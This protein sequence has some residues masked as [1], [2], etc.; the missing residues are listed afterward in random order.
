MK[1]LKRIVI[2]VLVLAVLGGLAWGGTTLLRKRSTASSSTSLTQVVSVERGNLTASIS[3]TGE[4]YAPRQA[5]LGFDVTRI[6]LVEL[7]VAAGQVAKKGDVLARIDRAPLERAVEQAQANLLSAEDALAEAKDP[8]AALDR[9][10]AELTVAQAQTAL[11]ETRQSLEDLQNPDLDAA[12]QA[13]EDASRQLKQAQDN[14]SALQKD[15][16]V[17]E[18]IDRL[19]WLANEAEAAHGKLLEKK[20]TSE[21][22]QDLLLVSYNQMMDAQEVL[23]AAKVQAKL[24]LLTAQYQVAQAEWTLEDAQLALADIQKGPTALELAQ[25]QNQVA[26]AEYNLTKAKDDLAKV[27]AGPDANTIQVAQASYDA[28]QAALEQAQ[29]TLDAATM[30]APFDGTVISVGAEVGDM[31]SSGNVVVTLA[32]LAQLEVL[33]SIDETDISQVQVGQAV[34]IT[35]DAFPG[36]QLAGKV[37]EVP[38]EGKLAQNVVTY[39]VPISL[40]GGEGVALKSGMTANLK[41]IVGQRENALLVPALAV[42]QGDTGN[43]VL[44]QDT[45]G[46]A[47]VQVPVE[48]GLSDGT[49][50]EVLRGLNEGDQVVVEY[51]TSQQSTGFGRFGGGEDLRPQE[52][53]GGGTVPGQP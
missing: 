14:L 30:V 17:Q 41:I 36:R 34:Q 40:E 16:S 4:V 35:F 27:Q 44:V 22:Q 28:A 18:Q 25:A 11:E 33:A 3:P 49:Y 32:D 31:V 47:A 15:T 29:A 43:V 10:R 46:G 45:P 38:L 9:Q 42:Q 21:A 26:Q 8:Y 23:E 13:V 1:W 39:Q 7:N 37:L 6:P 51:S 48:T 5:A 2:W 53:P 50:V 12:R 20:D 24:S 19:Q 52:L